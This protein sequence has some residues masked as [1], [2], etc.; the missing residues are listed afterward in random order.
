MSR[1]AGV[2]GG[3]GQKRGMACAEGRKEGGATGSLHEWC[4]FSAFAWRQGGLLFWMYALLCSGR[5]KGSFVRRSS[6]A[7]LY[8]VGKVSNMH[9]LTARGYRAANAGTGR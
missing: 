2:R 8:I 5:G 4:V 3:V 7:P 1:V 9:A 6:L